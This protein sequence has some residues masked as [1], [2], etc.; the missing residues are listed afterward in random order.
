MPLGYNTRIQHSSNNGRYPSR[1]NVLTRN[2]TN[3]SIPIRHSPYKHILPSSSYTLFRD[4][5]TSVSTRQPIVSQIINNVGKLPTNDI[6]NPN[7]IAT[8]PQQ[9]T[10]INPDTI[11]LKNYK[12]NV[13]LTYDDLPSTTCYRQN[14]PTHATFALTK[15]SSQLQYI[16]PQSLVLFDIDD[17]QIRK[18]IYSCSLL[19][20]EG[21]NMFHEYLKKHYRTTL[22][23]TQRQEYVNLIAKELKNF[24]LTE[25]DIPMTIQK[26]QERNVYTVGF[27]ARSNTLTNITNTTLQSLGI[28]FTKGVP[29]TLPTRALESQTGAA[30]V[31]GIVYCNN[32]DKGI[33][34][35]R[36]LQLQWLT[37]PQDNTINTNLHNSM[38]HN[39][40]NECPD[41]TVWFIDD[42]LSMIASMINQWVLSAQAKMHMYSHQTKWSQKIPC[43][44]KFSLICCHYLHPLAASTNIVD[45][46]YINDC[47][48]TQIETF[49][50][51]KVLIT[52][53]EAFKRLQNIVQKDT[54][55]ADNIDKNINSST[56]C[57]T[58]TD[59]NDSSVSKSHIDLIT[60]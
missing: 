3:N 25:E 35:Q 45:P 26:L 41:R 42:S 27:T 50:S 37:W 5:D 39:D 54:I 13:L 36:L 43:N 19:T 57:Q 17:T 40:T 1:R 53:H 31:D 7:T 6:N 56:T 12:K 15:M 22:S 20:A 59:S 38:Y 23:F 16:K 4:E 60:E 49:L 58:D 28:K 21:T 14:I 30:V 29:P 8:T 18:N 51:T 52:D 47:I 33:V 34:F 32:V 24:V 10:I 2:H 9:N 46:R 11:V 48:R 44:G 55:N